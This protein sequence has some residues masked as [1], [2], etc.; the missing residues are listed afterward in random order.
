MNVVDVLRQ[1][2]PGVELLGAE[3]AIE[4]DLFVNNP[5][6][7]WLSKSDFYRESAVLK[8]QCIKVTSLYVNKK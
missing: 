5:D 1:V 2:G 6:N 4:L 8:T 7:S 3:C